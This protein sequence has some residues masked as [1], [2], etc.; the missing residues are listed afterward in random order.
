GLKNFLVEKRGA[1]P[2]ICRAA[3]SSSKS[4][5]SKESTTA[6][7]KKSTAAKRASNGRCN[8][9]MNRARMSLRTE[10]GGI[11]PKPF[12]KTQSFDKLCAH[13][14]SKAARQTVTDN[15]RRFK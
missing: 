13:A 6:V 3:K 15:N 4:S 11:D 5:V 1:C 10:S 8:L 2:A 9:E 12:L 7:P 14:P